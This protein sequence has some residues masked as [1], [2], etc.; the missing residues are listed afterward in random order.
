MVKKRQ[1]FLFSVYELAQNSSHDDVI[2]AAEAAAIASVRAAANRERAAARALG[3]NNDNSTGI[4]DARGME[5]MEEDKKGKPEPPSRGIRRNKG[6]KGIYLFCNFLFY[7]TQA[8]TKVFSFRFGSNSQIEQMGGGSFHL[9]P[10]FVIDF[11][12]FPPT[13]FC[14]A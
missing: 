8:A 12:F 13:V 14:P 3:F 7:F 6:Y 1:E 11:S 9:T 2:S 5:L 10:S 4:E